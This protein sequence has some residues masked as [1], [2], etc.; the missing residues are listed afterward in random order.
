MRRLLIGLLAACA[1]TSAHAGAF[2]IEFG[3][4]VSELTVN[5]EAAPNVWSV[6]PPVRHLEFDDYLVVASAREGVCSIIAVGK[7]YES[8]AYGS[9]V[10]SAFQNISAALT[11]KYGPGQTTNHLAAGAIWGE[12]RDFAMSLK[13]KDRTLKTTWGDDWGST[14]RPPDISSITLEAIAL[15]QDST[16]LR[17]QYQGSNYPA[18][19]AELSSAQNAA[20]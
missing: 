5:N 9:S 19:Q 16:Y 2:G 7:V 20:L 3:T 15:T 4:P 8:D 14:N 18:C 6:L 1:A 17:L 11:Q 10:R 12:P 13:S